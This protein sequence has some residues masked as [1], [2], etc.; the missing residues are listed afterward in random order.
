MNASSIYEASISLKDGR[1]LGYARFGDPDGFPVLFFHG[2]PGSR[3]Q[4]PMD[5][6]FL[7]ELSLCLYCVE[8]PGIGLSTAQPGRSID[9]WNRDMEEF[10]TILQIKNF[11]VIGIS[12]GSPY[13]AA[14]AGHFKERIKSL[15][16]ISGTAPLSELVHFR[17]LPLRMRIIFT[18]IRRAPYF[19]ASLTTGVL[20]LVDNRI[21][22]LFPLLLTHLPSSDKK[23]LKDPE[24][25]TFFKD[26][27]LQAFRSGSMAVIEELRVLMSRW[28]VLPEEI[29]HNV[30]IW[31]GNEDTILPLSLARALIRRIPRVTA[32]L[33][34]GKGHF[35]ALENAGRIF[36]YIR[37]DVNMQKKSPGPKAGG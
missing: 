1:E 15:T 10:C 11:A 4:R 30:H 37:E 12:G 19:S 17:E 9:D 6:R 8:R 18:L 29:R 20:R 13:A 28:P 35:F 31:H 2:I 21:D 3:L 36:R 33:L 16:I 27:V 23:L 14:A 7:A 25:V 34:P 24:V 32:H 22:R 5:I 26:D